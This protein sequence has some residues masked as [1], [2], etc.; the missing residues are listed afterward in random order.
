MLNTFLII[1]FTFGIIIMGLS[2]R[3]TNETASSCCYLLG[4][5]MM[6]CVAAIVGVDYSYNNP[7]IFQR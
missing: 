6:V 7:D 3:I 1:A 5:L 2:F 4:L